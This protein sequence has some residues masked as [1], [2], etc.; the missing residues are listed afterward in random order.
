MKKSIKVDLST[1]GLDNLS[2][3]LEKFKTNLEKANTEIVDE[4][5][6][7]GLK[8]IQTNFS[9]FDIDGNEDVSFFKEGTNTH[10][11][12]GARGS[13]VLYVEF[14]TGTEGANNPHPLKSE[15]GLKGYNTGRTIR[16]AKPYVSAKTGILVG[17]KFWTYKQNG[18]IV[19]TTGIPSGQGVYRASRSIKKIKSKIIKEKVG[20]AL[21]KL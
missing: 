18:Q 8:E 15:F 9:T 12:I 5:A 20:D 4:I 16:S 13:Q 19:Y 2:K 7:Y 14:G 3:K 10:K 17:E 1:K 21:S 11:K 6:E